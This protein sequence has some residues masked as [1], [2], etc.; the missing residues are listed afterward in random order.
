MS[1]AKFTTVTYN[2]A[3]MNHW[4]A[5]WTSD[6]YNRLYV[7]NPLN[8]SPCSSFT[9]KLVGVILNVSF[10]ASHTADKVKAPALC[11]RLPSTSSDPTNFTHYLVQPSNFV[12]L[13]LFSGY[14]PPSQQTIK[15]LKAKKNNAS[16]MWFKDYFGECK[17]EM[18]FAQQH[19][20]APPASVQSYEALTPQVARQS[21]KDS[22]TGSDTEAPS[23]HDEPEDNNDNVNPQRKLPF[24]DKKDKGDK[25]TKEETE[26][27]IDVGGAGSGGAGSGTSASKTYHPKIGE[28]RP[29]H[30]A[31]AAAYA[32]QVVWHKRTAEKA[33]KKIKKWAKK[34]ADRRAK[35]QEEGEDYSTESDTSASEISEGSDFE[36]EVKKMTTKLETDPKSS[37]YL[38]TKPPAPA[39]LAKTPASRSSSTGSDKQGN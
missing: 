4:Q 32:K 12:V 5:P 36:E 23:E 18:P 26:D 22:P 13:R 19:V 8:P 7:L 10:K 25:D 30:L 9:P 39:T 14:L 37:Y 31:D 28:K 35:A 33:S 24:S 15:D 27:F 6:V 21:G 29:R 1:N 2:S 11:L 3:S 20:A 34:Q 16:G 17:K 38:G